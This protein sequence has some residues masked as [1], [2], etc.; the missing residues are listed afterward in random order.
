VLLAMSWQDPGVRPLLELEGL[1]AWQ[2]G[3]SSGYALLERAVD[4]EGFY[5][6]SGAITAGGYR[7]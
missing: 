1:R 7:Y 3:R 6:G 2:P 4:D 5:D